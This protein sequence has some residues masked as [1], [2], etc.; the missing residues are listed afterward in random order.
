MPLTPLLRKQAGKANAD[1]IRSVSSK[2]LFALKNSRLKKQK[3]KC[4]ANIEF[5]SSTCR[6]V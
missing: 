2:I 5:L 1:G 6:K 4:K 3:V